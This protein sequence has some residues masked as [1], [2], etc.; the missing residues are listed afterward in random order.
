MSEEVPVLRTGDTICV[1]GEAVRAR[2]LRC[3]Q[4]LGRAALQAIDDIGSVGHEALVE[5]LQSGLVQAE[6]GIPNAALYPD[7]TLSQ[8]L[9]SIAVLK[10]NIG[11]LDEK[12][13]ELEAHEKLVGKLPRSLKVDGDD[14]RQ[15]SAIIAR[16]LQVLDYDKLAQYLNFFDAYY[17]AT[18]TVAARGML[19][20]TKTDSNQE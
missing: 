18:C 5:R 11:G 14:L 16:F 17:D 10:A 19:A 2:L 6:L 8:S 7:Q 4:L 12:A 3:V 20:A 9:A 15:K 1:D 13:P